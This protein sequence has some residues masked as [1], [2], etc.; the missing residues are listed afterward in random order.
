M[1][2]LGVLLAIL[3]CVLL[4]PTRHLFGWWNA[5]ESGEVTDSTAFDVTDAGGQSGAHALSPFSKG[6]D[7]LFA[8]EDVVDHPGVD[9]MLIA[10]PPTTGATV[11]F[12]A[13]IA[14]GDFESGLGDRTLG[15]RG[16]GDGAFGGSP[17]EGYALPRGAFYIGGSASGFGASGSSAALSQQSDARQSHG[18]HILRSSVGDNS[19]GSGVPASGSSDYSN[20]PASGDLAGQGSSGDGNGGGIVFVS[21]GGPTDADV[22]VSVLPSGPDGSTL[23]SDSNT[24]S[25]SGPGSGGVSFSA[26]DPTPVPEP[27]TLLLLGAGLVL[28]G[29]RLNRR[30]LS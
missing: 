9:G 17:T 22:N 28:T 18:G 30:G 7:S 11:D 4:A 20:A 26:A 21:N 12:V 29:Y 5:D 16:I 1:I 3:L 2:V 14:D 10:S 25:P 19:D 8:L 23:L 15:A 6:V 13:L 27:A 24:D